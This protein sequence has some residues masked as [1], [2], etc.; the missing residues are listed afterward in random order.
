MLYTR[1]TQ[2]YQ[3]MFDEFL[4][5]LP[6]TYQQMVFNNMFTTCLFAND[7]M[8]NFLKGMFH[9]TAS[10]M[11][12]INKAKRWKFLNNK[13]ACKINL[14]Q[15]KD[16]NDMEASETFLETAISKM[17]TYFATPE[18]VIYAQGEKATSMLFI[19]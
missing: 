13:I 7:V 17:G 15:M 9:R 5:K 3:L 1:K 11:Q 4:I 14:Y 19:Q 18:E 8:V 12:K 2:D 16:E 10:L 6:P